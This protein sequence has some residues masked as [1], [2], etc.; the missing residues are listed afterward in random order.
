MLI[1][2]PRHIRK[3]LVLLRQELV[4]WILQDNEGTQQTF[5]VATP[6]FTQCPFADK[7]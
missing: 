6:E 4:T 2:P 5:H 3:K 1:D 7:M